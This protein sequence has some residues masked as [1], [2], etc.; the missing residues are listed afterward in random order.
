MIAQLQAGWRVLVIL[1][2]LLFALAPPAHAQ[3]KRVPAPAAP[4]APALQYQPPPPEE[5]PPFNYAGFGSQSVPASM[6]AGSVYTV[7]VSM[8]N[9]GTT[10]WA[11]GSH[12]LGSQNP[13]DNGTWG[14]SRAGLGTN[15]APGQTAVFSFQVTAPATPGAYNF[16][17]MM[18]Q[19]TV[20]WFGAP[21]TNLVVNVTAPAAQN[22]AQF[23]SQAVP[24]TMVTG[25]QYPVAVTFVNNGSTT[26][27]PTNG[28][29]SIAAVNPVNSTSWVY[30]RIPLGAPVLPGQQR[31]VS[32]T[33][34]APSA[35]G[36][37]NFQWMVI[38]EGVA[39]FGTPST[40]V[41]VTVGAPTGDT[42][43]YIHT[44]AL[45]SPVARSDASG[46]VISR[47]RY[48]PYGLTAAGDVPS[49]GFTGHVNDADT[50][51]VY[52]QQRY[53][54]PVAA[55]FLSIDPVVTNANTGSS[56]NRYAYANNSP[57]RYTDPDG[58]HPLLLIARLIV[59][60]LTVNDLATSEVPVVG[61]GA[62]KVGISAA[63]RLVI[64]Q[65]AGKAGEAATKAALG[66]AIAGEQVTIVT[67]TGKRTVADFI[68]NIAGKLGI[69]ETK[70]GKATLS[71]GQKQL[72]QDIK[73]GK[74]V[75]PVGE[76][77]KKAGLE[78]GEKIK[79]QEHKVDRQ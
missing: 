30:N 31:T 4:T 78:P 69:V 50:G 7:T 43:T 36:T 12:F 1:M 49:V 75:T 52:M 6:V 70:T 77:A 54:D 27:D 23:V 37:Y 61:G 32:W 55:R 53:Y 63:E 79:I 42:V 68:T 11:P 5:E 51:L 2:V 15:V 38:Q 45:G 47:T 22:N 8:V 71:S 28:N 44:D 26:W 56:F 58:R 29:Y 59:V 57:Y 62:A 65:A 33:V 16:Q 72:A 46:N 67:S 17:W 48:E 13:R 39:L 41:A 9:N 66:K 10:T 24:A 18:V 14:G 25:G 76:N 35:P 21:S 34:T 19:E 20:E 60:G 40:N 64:N 3:K 73:D 74:S